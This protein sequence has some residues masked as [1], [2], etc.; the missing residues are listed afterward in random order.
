M[1][2]IAERERGDTP[3]EFDLYECSWSQYSWYR[4]AHYVETRF[5]TPFDEVL[6]KWTEVLETRLSGVFIRL[7]RSTMRAQKKEKD[8]RSKVDY[9]K[10]SI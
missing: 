3:V 9:K 7:Y 1:L 5:Q 4:Q 6:V 2:D 8:V 10:H